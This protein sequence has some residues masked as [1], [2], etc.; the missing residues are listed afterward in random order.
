M[1]VL[2]LSRE[3]FAVLARLDEPGVRLIDLEELERNNPDVAATKVSRSALEYYFTLTGC[4]VTEVMRTSADDDFV[5]YVDADL[6]FYSSVRPLFEEMTGAS[7]GLVGHRY[8]WWKRSN[9]KFGYF[10]VCWTCFRCDVVGRRAATWWRDRCVEWCHDYVDGDRFADQKYLDH[11]HRKFPNVVEIKHAGANVAPWNLGRHK[12]SLSPNDSFCVDG[13]WPLIFFHF[14]GFREVEPGLFLINHL[15]YQAP[16]SRTVRDKL[17]A[18]YAAVLL[19][20]GEAVGTIR[21][22]PPLLDRGSTKRSLKQRYFE[23]R[24]KVLRRGAKLL[25]HYV[26][27]SV[28]FIGPL[29]DPMMGQAFACQVFLEALSKKYSV[30]VINLNKEGLSVETA[31]FR[32]IWQ[33]VRIALYAHWLAKRSACGYF[34]LSQSFSGNFRDLLIFLACFRI[35]PRA[36]VHLHGGPGMR[37]VL[38]ANRLLRF[39]NR[40]FFR[41]LGAVIV[42]GKRYVDIFDGVAQPDHVKIVPNFAP[43]ELYSS[44]SDILTKFPSDQIFSESNPLRIL[45]LSNHLPGKGHIELLHAYEALSSLDRSRVHIDFAG[46]FVSDKDRQTFLNSISHLP[47]VEHHGVAKGEK[48]KQLFHRAHIFCLPTYYRYEGQPISILESYAS[49]CVVLTTNHSGIP[50]IFI[51]G[52]NGYVV[53]KASSASIKHIIEQ[54]LRGPSSLQQMALNNRTDAEIYP[55]AKYNMRLLRIISELMLAPNGEHQEQAAPFPIR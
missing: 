36:A 33:V 25:K 12:I 9:L 21:N 32:R 22:V 8:H 29:P 23:F 39:V 27:T 46:D 1:V 43:E 26:S 17:Y 38:N 54:V 13:A 11:M 30:H 24:V 40:F 2:C 31:V 41:R 48:K 18:P 47:N 44:E 51:P 37:E 3:C 16:L 15:A 10:N 7:V 28:L 52:R 50:D 20:I 34:N 42:L 4:I 35:L 6:M 19:E 49:G 45:L 53:D 5:T 55:T 14:Q